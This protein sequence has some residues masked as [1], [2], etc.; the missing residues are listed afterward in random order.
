MNDHTSVDPT[1]RDFN[2]VDRRF[3]ARLASNPSYPAHLRL[4]WLAM[5]RMQPNQHASFKPGEIGR[6]LATA[7][8]SPMDRSNVKRALRKAEAEGL[9]ERNSTSRCVIVGFEVTYGKRTSATKPCPVDHHP[10]RRRPVVKPPTLTLVRS[11]E[12]HIS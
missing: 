5:A 2:M 7:S 12:T 10:V 3:W 8:G 4:W 9:L 11:G 6:L 1:H